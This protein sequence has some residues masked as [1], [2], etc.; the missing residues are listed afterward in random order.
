MV[1]SPRLERVAQQTEYSSVKS[2]DCGEYVGVFSEMTDLAAVQPLVLLDW[3]RPLPCVLTG[4]SLPRSLSRLIVRT[5]IG[6]MPKQQPHI[7]QGG[8]FLQRRKLG[9]VAI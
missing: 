3:L 6:G 5:A 4:S 1:R 9:L 8:V 2:S 7:P